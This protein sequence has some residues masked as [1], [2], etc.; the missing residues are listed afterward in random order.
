M[1]RNILVAL[2]VLLFLLVLPV[3]AGPSLDEYVVL[4]DEAWQSRADMPG[5]KEK[6]EKLIEEPLVF[7]NAQ[8]LWR[9]GRIYHWLGEK[10]AESKDV[11]LFYYTNGKT[12]TEK[13]VELAP[14]CPHSN[15]W[16][17]A[18]IGKE[19]E[20]RGILQ[21]LFM[22]RPMHD[23]LDAVLAID[24]DYADAYYALGILYRLVPGWPLSIGN[25]NKSLEYALRAVELMPENLEYQ[26]GLAETYLAQKNKRKAKEV[27]EHIIAAPPLEGYPVES[28]DSKR[29]AAKL[30][31]GLKI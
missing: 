24:A 1:N 13:A 10:Y 31:K 4:F 29:V 14:D 27:L 17:A 2:P 19:G 28:E 5:L 26:L 6:V 21:S 12:Y 16:L 18:L 15:F 8:L 20:T 11:K 30:L 22:V 23:R 3:T 9:L 7:D 25:L